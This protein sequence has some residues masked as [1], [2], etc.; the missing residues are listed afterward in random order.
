M[1]VAGSNNTQFDI[2][3]APLTAA[4]HYTLVPGPHIYDLAGNPMDQ[5]G[6]L[7]PGEPTDAFT[8]GGNIATP[9]VTASSPSGTVEPTVD[10]VPAPD[11]QPGHGSDL[12]QR[13]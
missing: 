4:G 13:R 12:L 9:L 11:L 8:A 10:H 6:D 1:A 7:I 5:D 2:F 3:F